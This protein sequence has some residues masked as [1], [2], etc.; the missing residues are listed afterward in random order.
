MEVCIHVKR[1][2]CGFVPTE[3]EI[4]DKEVYFVADVSN[5]EDS[6]L[7]GKAFREHGGWR[8]GICVRWFLSILKKSYS[9][10]T[11][12]GTLTFLGNNLCIIL[13]P[14]NGKD[15]NK[16]SAVHKKES[17]ELKGLLSTWENKAKAAQ[18]AAQ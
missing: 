11:R 18:E 6:N 5:F 2:Y 10:Q 8:M 17:R 7:I 16:G 14:Y 3:I 12:Q 1:N 4:K 13:I 9:C 15:G